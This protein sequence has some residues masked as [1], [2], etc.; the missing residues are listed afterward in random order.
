MSTTEHFVVQTTGERLG[1]SVTTVKKH[2]IRAMTHC[3][4]LTED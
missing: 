4:L 3:L 2:V 1:V